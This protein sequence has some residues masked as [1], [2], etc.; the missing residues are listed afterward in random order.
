MRIAILL[1]VSVPLAAVLV[2]AL[3]AFRS[4]GHSYVDRSDY[5]AL[6]QFLNA[7]APTG[8]EEQHALS[9]CPLIPF[10]DLTTRVHAIDNEWVPNPTGGGGSPQEASVVRDTKTDVGSVAVSCYLPLQTASRNYLAVF[11]VAYTNPSLSP[12][13]YAQRYAQTNGGSSY[14]VDGAAVKSGTAI[15]GNCMSTAEQPDGSCAFDWTQDGVYIE[16]SVDRRYEGLGRVLLGRIVP[17]VANMLHQ[18]PRA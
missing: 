8:S 10:T 11:V 4:T 17:D 15:K 5:A 6:T 9:S 1:A 18:L 14:E 12:K 3:L 2:T 13:Q 7:N 16:V